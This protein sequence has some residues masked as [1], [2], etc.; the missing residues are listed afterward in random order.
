MYKYR[1]SSLGVNKMSCL[2][3]LG[4]VFKAFQALGMIPFTVLESKLIFQHSIIVKYAFSVL[5][6]GAMNQY[7]MLAIFFV[8]VGWGKVTLREFQSATGV[9]WIDALG[10]YMGQS[11]AILFGILVIICFKKQESVLSQAFKGIDYVVEKFEIPVHIWRKS[12]LLN[13]NKR[14]RFVFGI[15]TVTLLLLPLCNYYGYDI[16]F[17]QYLSDGKGNQVWCYRV[18]QK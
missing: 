8:D 6:L 5:V 10:I 15:V 16:M 11:V 17:K 7:L 13:I 3:N 4:S 2:E 14:A 9:K 12:V 1:T 18:L